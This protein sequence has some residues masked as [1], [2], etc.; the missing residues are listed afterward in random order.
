MRPIPPQ[1][2]ALC[3]GKDAH[4]LMLIV[5]GYIFVA[6]STNFISNPGCVSIFMPVLLK[7]A[8]EVNLPFKPLVVLVIAA[9][10][11]NF[12]TPVGCGHNILSFGAVK[13]YRFVDYCKVSF[14]SGES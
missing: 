9:S 8:E 5:V 1:V 12:M 3:G 13:E 11:A 10:V 14:F 7:V 6:G 2:T 4:P